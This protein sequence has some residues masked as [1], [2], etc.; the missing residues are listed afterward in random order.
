MQKKS[1]LM[2][3]DEEVL[4]L[5]LKTDSKIVVEQALWAGIRPGMRVADLGCG[6]GKT[7]FHL[8]KLTQPKGETLGIDFSK[9]RINY[10]KEHYSAKGLRFLCRDVRDPLNDIG[11]FDFIWIRFLLEYYRREGFQ[12]LKHIFKILKPGGI[13]CLIDLDYNCLTYYG[14]P[15]RLEKA[16]H[17]MMLTV[18]KHADFDPFVGR[19]LYTYLYDLGCQEIEVKLSSHN[20]IYGHLKNTDEFNWSKKVEAAGKNSG[21]TFQEYTGGYPEFAEEFKTAFADPRRF[22]YTPVICAKGLKPK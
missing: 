13:L 17:A 9:Q 21:Y 2:E 11:A 20:L 7:S 15:E 1:Y 16:I 3:S 8:N 22:M 5:D 4:R 18:E 6:S 19:K 14:I 12:I 10:G